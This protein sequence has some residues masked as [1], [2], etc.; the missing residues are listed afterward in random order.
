MTNIHRYLLLALL[1]ATAAASAAAAVLR[2]R[3]TDNTGEALMQASVR[4]LAAKDS[5]LVKGAV[6][7][8]SGRFAIEGLKQGRY[9]VETSYVG[10]ATSTQNITVGT[11]DIRLQPIVL[12]E[13][14][15]AL[16]E[17]VVTGIRTPVKVMEDTVEFNADSYHTQPNSMVED[18][19]KRLPGV[20]VGSDGK[21]TA[22]GQ[23]VKKI[24]VDGKEFFSDDPTVASRNLPVEMVEKLQVVNRKSDLARLTGVDDGEDETVINLTVKKG[25][26]NGW[27]GNAEAGYGTDDRYRANFTVNRFWGDNQITFLGA[28]N[29]VNDPGFADG[30]GDRFRRFGGDNGITTSQSI[31][32]NFNVGNKEIFRVGGDVMYS[33][34][35]R[36]TRT[37]SDRQ[38]IFADSTSTSRSNKLS[39][40][41]GHNFRADLRI[42]W[43]P[44]SFNTFDFRPNISL[45]YNDS[46]SRDTTATFGG[47]PDYRQVT[48]SYN[49]NVSSG[50]SF[51]FGGRLIY[52]HNFRSRP[53]RSFSV[54]ANYSMSNVR[55]NNNSYSFNKFFLLN[56]SVDLYDQYA[57]NH[58]WS[59]SVSTRVSWTEPLGDVAKG[60]FLVLAY[61]FSY[62]WNNADKLTYD[63]PVAFPDGWEGAPV[64]SDEEVFNAD[65]SNRFRND[66]MSQNIR[67]GYRHVSKNGNL[68]VGVSLVPQ[69][70]QSRNLINS[71][72]DIPRRS[73]LN[74]APFLRYQLRLTRTRSIN[75]F[76]NGRSSQPSMT[77]LQPVAD[78]SDPLR[79]VI[80][81]PNLDPTFNH[82]LRVRFQDFNSD[83]QRSIMAM[84]DANYTQNSIVSR[85]TYDPSTGGQ[86]T[87]YENVNGVWS[88]RGFNLIS[89]PLRNKAFTFNNHLMVSYSHSVGFNNGERNR[90]GNFGFNESFGMA[91]RP[92]NLEFELRPSYGLQLVNNS[93]ASQSDRTVHTYGGTFYANYNTPIGIVLGTD[94]NYAATS[95][96]SAGYDTRSWMW[97]ATLSYQFL[98]GRNATVSLKAYD[99]LGQRSNVRRTVTANYID[100]TRYNSLTRYFMVSLSYKFTTFGKGEQPV[101]HNARRFGPGGP[102]PG[103]RPG[104]PGGPGG[105]GRF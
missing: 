100:D 82:N 24:L 69:T 2:G 99:I 37:S 35:D 20:E 23:E 13:S 67:L 86:T 95:G 48:Q 19:L 8:D 88:I 85:T 102:P 77:Q 74:F 54:M 38:Y 61:N 64:I 47:A 98:R 84:M 40:D 90:S 14:S 62:R 78:M 93:V 72:K 26:K 46:Y 101:D 89:M 104:G 16:R 1:V 29:N 81:N 79:I 25:M 56:D 43:K 42:E 7:N 68:N 44:D 45:N 51:E 55:E 73:V 92:E 11:D 58:T 17:A 97:N 96:Y 36:D 6:T 27:F 28:A 33:H 53:G 39:R 76:Y 22:N 21:I 75:A 10:Y 32:V 31:G 49:N 60:N 59:N 83:A 15:V 66:Y 3:V 30:A 63:H 91:W 12:S 5:T 4:I 41:K 80:G 57:D 18:L 71:D 87:T 52:T 65:L 105:P 94:L 70:S 103:G 9:I 34:T 50:H